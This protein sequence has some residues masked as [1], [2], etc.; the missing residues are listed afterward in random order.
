M[1]TRRK[2]IAITAA[3]L[4]VGLAAVATALVVERPR[5]RARR[6]AWPHRARR[7][8]PVGATTAR[9][10]GASDF[11]VAVDA[12][13]AP[14]R[15]TIPGFA[16]GDPP[17]PV[18]RLQTDDGATTDVVRDEV[19]VTTASDEELARLPRSLGRH[20]PR[21]L[22]GRAGRARRP[23]RPHRP[24]PSAHGR[25]GRRPAGHRTARRR[26]AGRR[27]G[28]A[29]AP[30]HRRLRRRPLRH[31]G[32][33]QRAR[34]GRRHR[35][36]QPERGPGPPQPVRLVVDRF[37][38]HPADRPRRRLAAARRPRQA[39]R[40]HRAR[41]GQRRRLLPQPRLPAGRV[42]DAAQRHVGRHQPDGLR[43]QGLPVPRQ[44]RGAGAHGPA[45]Q[46]LRHRRTG[47]SGGRA[48]RR[49]GLRGQVEAAAQAGGHGR[50]AP[51]AH[52]EHELQLDDHGVPGR[53]PRRRRQ[54]LPPDGG[55]RRPAGGGGRQP[56]PRRATPAPAWAARAPRTA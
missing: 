6:G 35:R 43:R 24:G 50:R 25:R 38:P 3:G 30:G 14:H 45:R 41:H 37:R 13:V 16:D 4:V 52:R 27:R 1:D 31:R 8:R 9:S 11:T 12:A 53:Q 44:R 47:R 2:R 48:G 23:P 36:R 51:P 54:A 29:E 17:R 34:A 39:R 22:A 49:R 10:P 56:G 19:I 32:A 33:P 20:G 28:H 21:Q 15:A 26:A 42:L 7:P 5:G 46:R 18:G 55:R 40:A